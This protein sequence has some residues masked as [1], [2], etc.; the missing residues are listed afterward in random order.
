MQILTQT[1]S[2]RHFGDS[3]I[4]A[5]KLQKRHLVQAERKSTHT[6]LGILAFQ[7]HLIP[8]QFNFINL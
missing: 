3:G 2:R 7:S 6:K 5:D 4:L 1:R 8:L